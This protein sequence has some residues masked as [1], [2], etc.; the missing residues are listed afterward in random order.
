MKTLT[1]IIILFAAFLISS[2]CIYILPFLFTPIEEELHTNL[3]ELSLVVATS[4]IGG[5]IGGIVIGRLADRIGRRFSLTLAVVT[6]GL[7]LLLA[8][9]VSSILIFFPLLFL[10]GLGVN[11]EN[12]VSYALVAEWLKGKRGFTGGFMQGLYF[13][14]AILSAI[15]AGYLTFLGTNYWRTVLTLLGTITIIIGVITYALPESEVWRETRNVSNS[16]K[17]DSLGNYMGIT[18]AGSAIAIGSLLYL[19]PTITLLPTL[20]EKVY[21]FS[22]AHASEL[23]SISFII[24]FV[25]YLVDGYLAD[26]L[27]R[28]V[29]VL[30]FSAIGL[31]LS[32]LML[33]ITPV[34]IIPLIFFFSGFFAHFGVWISEFYPPKLRVTA[35]NVVFFL[36]RLVG[37]GFGAFI[38]LLLPFGLKGDIVTNLAVSLILVI[39][40]AAYLSKVSARRR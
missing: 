11:G 9:L 25:G 38:I 8:G 7:F 30:I 19:V 4:W 5:A 2:S 34:Y 31:I 20:L 40:G 1:R 26:K 15:S 13:L 36:G 18:L 29:P 17:G 6:S 23:L 27:G 22:P 28:E 10:V 3:S 39:V 24:G 37:G 21:F 32:L 14:G 16:V 12:G 33:I 35:N